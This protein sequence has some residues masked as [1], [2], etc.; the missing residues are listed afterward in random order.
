MEQDTTRIFNALHRI[1][2]S[3]ETQWGRSGRIQ[4]SLD[5]QAEQLSELSARIDANYDRIA[6]L[7]GQRHGKP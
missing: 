2:S 3:L 4:R 6:A 1:S 7:L 5:E